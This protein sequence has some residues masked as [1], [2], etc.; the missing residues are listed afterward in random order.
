MLSF[1]D[2]VGDRP[3]LAGFAMAAAQIVVDDAGEAGCVVGVDTVDL[4][5]AVAS[6]GMVPMRVS[7]WEQLLSVGPGHH[8]PLD[9]DGRGAV[10]VFDPTGRPVHSPVVAGIAG[11]LVVAASLAIERARLVQRAAVRSSVA[12]AS[13]LALTWHTD[14]LAELAAS[15]GELAGVTAVLVEIDDRGRPLRVSIGEASAQAVHRQFD[16]G[17]RRTFTVEISTAADLPPRAF[18]RIDGVCGAVAHELGGGRQTT[19]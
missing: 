19:V 2:L 9:R 7:T 11:S 5:F 17:G 6:R 4:P 12:A 3:T 15:I 14:Q 8:L 1:V 13:A 16:L 10:A 18:T